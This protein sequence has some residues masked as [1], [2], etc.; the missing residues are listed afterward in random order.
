M[1]G[2]EPAAAR[3]I[4]GPRDALAR[5]VIRLRDVNWLGS[6]G[7]DHSRLPETVFVKIR[8]TRPAVAARFVSGDGDEV[9]VQLDEPDF[10][11]SPGQ[12]CVFY[13]TQGQGSRVLGGGYIAG[14]LR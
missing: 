14:T 12:A 3:V 6:A 11:I 2:L 7:A 13:E 9:R 5:R 1:T 4:V 8:S 10:G